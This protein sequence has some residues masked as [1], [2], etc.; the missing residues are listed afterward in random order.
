ME[1]AIGRF[2]WTSLYYDDVEHLLYNPGWIR[3]TQA[4][5]M[6]VTVRMVMQR[7][8][9]LE[10]PLHH[11]IHMF[12][13]LAPNVFVAKLLDMEHADSSPLRVVSCREWTCPSPARKTVISLL[14]LCQPDIFIEGGGAQLAIEIKSKSKSSREQVLKYA[15]LMLLRT[16]LVPDREIRKL[17]FVAPCETFADL[18]KGKAYADVNSLRNGLREFDDPETD[19][20]F[21]RFGLSLEEVK[22]SLDDLQIAWRPIRD[23][24]RDVHEELQQ[25]TAPGPAAEVY[26]KLLSGFEGELGRWP[27][28]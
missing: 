23:V 2:D 13:T 11:A 3:G 28:G 19:R 8:R 21:H 16:R 1:D 10:A 14:E 26:R 12:L 22:A 18:W 4:D 27:V 24:R 20:K 6:R 15:A 25:I 17:V 5:G 7:L 9:G